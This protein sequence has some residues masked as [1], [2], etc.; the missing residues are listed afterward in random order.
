MIFGETERDWTFVLRPNIKAEL[1][2]HRSHPL[3]IPLSFENRIQISGFEQRQSGKS[4]G[5]R[6]M[7]FVAT[8]KNTSEEALR[9]VE[10]HIV[11]YPLSR[12]APSFDVLEPGEAQEIEV[13][14][15]D[16][17]VPFASDYLPPSAFL[18][19]DL[20]VYVLYRCETDEGN[21]WAEKFPIEKDE[22][23]DSTE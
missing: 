21:W 3:G 17:F 4:S 1:E 13:S 16:A 10:T 5:H 11:S 15:E 7:I 18:A 20:F 22:L 12:S 23:L 14:W 8:L 9:D 6:D 2:L 19:H